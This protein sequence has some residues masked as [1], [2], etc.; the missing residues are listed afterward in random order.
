MKK[1]LA[2]ILGALISTSTFAECNEM[3]K[4]YKLK[5]IPASALSTTGG[6]AIIGAGA[7]SAEVGMILGV[8][9]SQEAFIISG[10]ALG[11]GVSASGVIV[12]VKGVKNGVEF[13]KKYKAYN[14]IKEAQAGTGDEVN[15][16][17]MD[18]SEELGREVT[19]AQVVSLINKGNNENTFCPSK[20]ELFNKKDIVAFIKSNI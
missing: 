6:A 8:L 19:E 17:A 12:S 16:L 9:A 14:L 2:I 1:F 7:Y 3:Y 5:K 13:I 11:L 18:L 15:E 4:K 20:N 10:I